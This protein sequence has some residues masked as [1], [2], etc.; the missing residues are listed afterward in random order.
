MAPVMRVVK[1]STKLL[2]I[3]KYQG[4][5]EHRGLFYMQM[6]I[7]AVFF[8]LLVGCFRETGNQSRLLIINLSSMSD[9]NNGDNKAA[10]MNFI[11]HAV[12]ADADAPSVAA[13]KLFAFCVFVGWHRAGE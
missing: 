11:D 5:G 9:G 1:R 10:V 4:P 13:L 7:K 12:V 2:I 3:L 8:A 6:H